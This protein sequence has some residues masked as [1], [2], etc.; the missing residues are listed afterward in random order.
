MFGAAAIA[1]AVA[2]GCT[3]GEARAPK[4]SGTAAVIDSAL[5]IEEAL[6]RFREGR[7]EP[8]ALRGGVSSRESLARGFVAALEARDT[9]ALRRLVL[10]AEEFAWLYYPASALSKP[11]YQL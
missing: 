8:K 4:P 9:A 2:V 3:S 5:P 11:P 7:T 1:C 6:R 10:S